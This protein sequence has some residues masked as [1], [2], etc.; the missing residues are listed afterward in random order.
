MGNK[1]I[2]HLEAWVVKIMCL[3]KVRLLC[4]TCGRGRVT[5]E[6]TST[7]RITLICQNSTERV[8]VH[9]TIASVDDKFCERSIAALLP[10]EERSYIK[11]TFPSRSVYLGETATTTKTRWS[12]HSANSSLGTCCSSPE[13]YLLSLQDP[14]RP[15]RHRR[16]QKRP[17][18]IRC[19]Q[20]C[21]SV[22]T[23][24]CTCVFPLTNAL[25]PVGSSTSAW[26]RSRSSMR[27]DT[28]TW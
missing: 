22:G 4:L 3:Y 24:A 20:V 12:V 16:A 1:K 19:A 9:T 13:A 14:Y 5:D 10:C 23:R 26:I 15:T 8:I 2:Y 27:R 28:H 21:R 25:D 18:D 7:L 11:L 6:H 17:L